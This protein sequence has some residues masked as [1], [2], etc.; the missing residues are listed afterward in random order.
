[1]NSL[2][3]PMMLIA[4]GLPGYLEWLVL[5]VVVCLVAIVV[6]RRKPVQERET[7]SDSQTAS[8]A[9]RVTARP[10]RH[11]IE[12]RHISE[13]RSFSWFWPSSK[14]GAAAFAV[15][16]TLS[17]LTVLIDPLLFWINVFVWYA[18]AVAVRA[19]YLK[20]SG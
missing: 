20:L 14:G 19:V 9:Q 17:A 18:V 6:L 13:P 11:P 3:I 4:F 16:L 15:V 2:V 12:S 5:V 7:N 10:A 8:E 1:M